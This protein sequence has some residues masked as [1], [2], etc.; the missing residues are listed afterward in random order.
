MSWLADM[1]GLEGERALDVGTGSGAFALELAARFR[2]VV[3]VDLPGA[4]AR[5][6]PHPGVR[7]EAMDAEALKFPD[8]SFDFVGISWSLHHLENPSG[9]LAEM[10]RVLR[11]GGVFMIVEPIDWP[12]GTNQ[13][14]HLAAHQLVA[15]ADRLAGKPHFPIF[16]RLQVGSVIQG[17]RLE[18]LRFDPLER[19]S[20]EEAWDEA[21]CR[22]QARGFLTKVE[23]IASNAGL[24]DDLRQRAAGVAERLRRE[25]LR[26]SPVMRVYGFKPQA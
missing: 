17:L 2:E 26:T 12:T 1:V 20:D 18:D 21:T 23:E 9:V 14:H 22:E 25:G 16:R 4:I 6:T 15:E 13:D 5:A 19:L 11:P 8:A 10:R 3:G 7:Y 24:S